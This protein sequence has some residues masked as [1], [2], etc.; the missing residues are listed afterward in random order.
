MISDPIADMLTTIRNGGAAKNKIVETPTSKIKLEILKV[1]KDSLYITDYK[2]EDR[3][4]KI[5]LKYY[6]KDF[7]IQR[8]KRISKPGVRIYRK[9][10]GIK[11]TLG[12]HGMQIVST[13]KGLMTDNQ[14]RKEKMGG[15]V[16]CEIW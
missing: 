4:I 3:V 7:V 5:F 12:G 10:K 15:E 2:L 16:L 9:S 13:P 6:D 8:I 11:K 14:A 1:L